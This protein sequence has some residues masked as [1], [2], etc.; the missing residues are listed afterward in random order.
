MLRHGRLAY[1][2]LILSAIFF[3]G[4]ASNNKKN[5][6]RDKVVAQSGFLCEFINGEQNRQVEMELNVMMAKRC[7]VEKPF[8]I[9]NYKTSAEVPGVLYCCKTKD[10]TPANKPTTTPTLTTPTPVT[11][12]APTSGSATK[13][14]TDTKVADKKITTVDKKAVDKKAAPAATDKKT[15]DLLDS[16]IE[17]EPAK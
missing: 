3:T 15:P 10:Q 11:T 17:I 6:L 1:A 14:A 12:S 7:D 2:F 5:E 16:D 13:P 9:T 4:C 8:S